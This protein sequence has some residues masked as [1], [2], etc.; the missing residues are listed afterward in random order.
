MTAPVVLLSHRGTPEPS[1]D[2]QRRLRAVH[3]RL[4]LR[5][6]ESLAEYWAICMT[7]DDND[8]RYEMIRSQIINPE[9]SFDIIGYLPM[10]CSLDE[11]PS[12]LAKSFR[13]YPVQEVQTL[14]QH[15]AVFNESL[16][17]QIAEKALADLLDRPDPSSTKSK[18]RGRT[19]KT[20]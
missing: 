13:E 2:I 11:A 4:F 12:Y 10:H 1:P 6:V 18:L 16:T 20:I 14:A 8:R 15:I 3:P 7:W 17:D 5:Y 9:K 19:I